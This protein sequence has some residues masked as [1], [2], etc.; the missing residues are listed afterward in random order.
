MGDEVDFLAVDKH[1]SLS[2]W[3]CVA[4]HDQ[5]TKNNKFIISSQYPKENGKDKV[6]FLPA[7]KH[8]KFLQIDTII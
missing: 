6:D 1:K 2:I 4:R 7:F 8:Q 5:K 3:V